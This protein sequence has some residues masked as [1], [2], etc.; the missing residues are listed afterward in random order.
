MSIQSSNVQLL[1]FASRR[2]FTIIS[3]IYLFPK[4]NFNF[5]DKI[6]QLM[7]LQLYSSIFCSNI[8]AVCVYCIFSHFNNKKTTILN[9]LAHNT[10]QHSLHCTHIE[11][12]YKQKYFY[13]W[14]N[15]MCVWVWVT[16]WLTDWLRVETEFF[17]FLLYLFLL[18]PILQMLARHLFFFLLQ[19]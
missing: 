15:E 6:R 4:N 10:A 14:M 3:F 13:E 11:H 8:F 5:Y 2:L 9:V 12:A 19:N 17:F 18:F 1:L 16:D 7:P